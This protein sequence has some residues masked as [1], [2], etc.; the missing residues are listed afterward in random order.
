MT[1][2][3][4]VERALSNTKYKMK[5]EE[6]MYFYNQMHF[7]GKKKE[8]HTADLLDCIAYLSTQCLEKDLEM[9]NREDQRMLTEE[10]LL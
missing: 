1:G 3:E 10:V 7:L 5:S 6:N 9:I 8:I 2:K 4:F